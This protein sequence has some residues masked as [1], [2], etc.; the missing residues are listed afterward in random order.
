MEGPCLTV[1]H[2]LFAP[3][4]SSSFNGSFDLPFLKSGPDLYEFLEPLSWQ[5]ELTNT[6]GAILMT[7]TV[8]GC[9]KT[10][11]ARCL[12]S[13]DMRLVGEVEGYFLLGQDDSAPHDREEDEFEVLPDDRV[14]ELASYLKAAILL[15]LPLIPLCDQDCKGLCPQCG[16][17]RNLEACTCLPEQCLPVEPANPFDILK[18]ISFD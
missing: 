10:A 9:A 15:E 6:G 18:D 12:E 3:A 2:E 5:V 17:N 8:E 16:Q 13:F 11:C 7:G 1:A 14:I 4:E